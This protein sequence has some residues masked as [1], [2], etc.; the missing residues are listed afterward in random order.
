[1]TG[2]RRLPIVFLLETDER[3]SSW[4]SRMAQ[5]Y[6]MTVSD[7]LTELGL[8]DRDVF[9]VELQMSEGEGA[10]IALRTGLSVD[11]LQATT[12]GEF[13][14]EA[15]M[16]IARQNRQH[17][18]LCP[19][20]IHRKSLALP[21]VFRCPVHGAD[22]QDATGTTLPAV[23]GDARMAALA[24]YAKAGSVILDAWTRGAEHGVL[25][26]PEMLAVLTARHRRASPPSLSE[27]PRMSLQTR[28]DYHEFLTTPIIRQSLAVVVPEYDQVAPV[29]AKPVRPGLHGL[30][31][32][33]LLQGFALTVGIGRL[34]ED[35]VARAIDVL[36]ASDADGQVR[37]RE[38]LKSWPLSLRRRIFARLWR[39]QRDERERQIAEKPTRRRQSHEFGRAQSHEYRSRIS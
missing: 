35:P 8:P 15:Q 25:D 29:L 10:L 20:D 7:F 21:W 6:A 9:D 19:G 32:G 14:P 16:M 31:Q 38:A 17:C 37:V 23:V 13:I 24:T 4:L 1:V 27:Q 2:E 36:L 12:F 3:L 26:A 33:S 28:R 34:A 18:P 39:A 30:A 11:A 5:F 22:L